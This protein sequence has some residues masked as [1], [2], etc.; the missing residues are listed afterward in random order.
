[1]LHGLSSDPSSVTLSH[2]LKVGARCKSNLVIAKES[3][4]IIAQQKIGVKLP[5]SP[6]YAKLHL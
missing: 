1:L 2:R 5:G 3:F 6:S 4:I